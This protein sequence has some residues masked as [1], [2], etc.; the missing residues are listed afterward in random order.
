MKEKL[1][2]KTRR[3]KDLL[4]E[5]EIPVEYYFGVQTTRAAQNFNIS[6]QGCTITPVHC[7]AGRCK[8]SC[9]LA[10]HHLGMLDEK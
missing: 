5:M 10:N 1:S 9:A 3:E 4:G 8:S 6:R 2:G 7:R